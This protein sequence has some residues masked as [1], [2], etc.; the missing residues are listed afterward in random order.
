MA[1]RISRQLSSVYRCLRRLDE[2]ILAQ[3][4][5]EEEC[6][7]KSCRRLWQQLEC[8]ITLSAVP[9]RL[10]LHFFSERSFRAAR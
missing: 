10:L 4:T 1:G 3:R 6:V 5:G 8:R 7:D 2:H 9:L